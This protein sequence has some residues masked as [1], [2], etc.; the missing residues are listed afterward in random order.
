MTIVSSEFIISLLM[1]VGIVR[2]EEKAMKKNAILKAVAA[3][4]R[5]SA[6]KAY[7]AS[8]AYGSYQPKEPF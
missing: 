5:K 7:N 6:L 4:G 3:I 2:K 8:S 1:F